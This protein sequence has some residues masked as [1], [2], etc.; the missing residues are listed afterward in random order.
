MAKFVGKY[1]RVKVGNTDLSANVAAVTINET[2]DE[3]EST[4]F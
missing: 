1:T 2:V 3:I 4:A